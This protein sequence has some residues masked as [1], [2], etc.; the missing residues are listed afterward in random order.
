MIVEMYK[1]RRLKSRDAWS[2]GKRL[3]RVSES[4]ATFL[5]EQDHELAR[6]LDADLSDY[7]YSHEDNVLK[8]DVASYLLQR[9]LK[10]GRC[11]WAD[12]HGPIFSLG[13]DRQGVLDWHIQNQ[14]AQIMIKEPAGLALLPLPNPWY[15]DAE[16]HQICL[17]YT[18]P[19]P[20]DGLLSRMPSSA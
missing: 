20:R 9:I 19:S 17:L 5:T 13:A 18:S 10:T 4:N 8:G 2:K 1:T 12:M 11:H 15:L 16:Q 14:E 3:W 6:L 7:Y